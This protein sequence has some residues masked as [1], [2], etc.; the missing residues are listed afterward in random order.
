MPPKWNPNTKMCDSQFCTLGFP[1]AASGNIQKKKKKKKNSW[2]NY[3]YYIT[4]VSGPKAEWG[5]EQW[6]IHNLN[7]YVDI[8]FIEASEWKNNNDKKLTKPIINKI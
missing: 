8:N 2:N 1:F 6:S 3:T 4:E 5:M 7:L